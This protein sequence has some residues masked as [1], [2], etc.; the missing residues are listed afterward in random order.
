MLVFSIIVTNLK[1]NNKLYKVKTDGTNNTKIGDDFV[2]NIVPTKGW[3]YYSNLSDN[4]YL[5]KIKK[6]DNFV[7]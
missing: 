4:A 3:I 1:D 5:Y 2:Q 7:C 6:D